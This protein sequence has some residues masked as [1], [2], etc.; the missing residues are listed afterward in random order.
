MT[1]VGTA[2]AA[3]VVQAISNVA[4]QTSPPLFVRIS[5][6]PMFFCVQKRD[7]HVRM[8][9]VL[10]CVCST[11]RWAP[12]GSLS[13]TRQ[14]SASAT[15]CLPHPLCCLYVFRLYSGKQ[16]RCTLTN[17]EKLALVGCCILALLMLI[18]QNEITFLLRNLF[19]EKK[20]WV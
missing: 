13:K 8:S 17:F 2:A 10:F 11:L 5:R 4:V 15:F 9:C 6:A 12:P 3:T 16:L 7:V 19:I 14:T 18:K 1:A 20:Y